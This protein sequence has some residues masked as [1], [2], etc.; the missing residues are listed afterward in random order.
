MASA[1]KYQINEG[2]FVVRANQTRYMGDVL[3]C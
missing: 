2:A 3:V 1:T